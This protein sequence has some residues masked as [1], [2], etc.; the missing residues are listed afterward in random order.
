MGEKITLQLIALSISVFFLGFIFCDF[1][2]LHT[3]KKLLWFAVFLF[4]AITV[5]KARNEFDLSLIL[6][7]PTLVAMGMGVWQKRKFSRSK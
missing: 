2:K 6:P 1:F 7:V 5:L 3:A 4:F